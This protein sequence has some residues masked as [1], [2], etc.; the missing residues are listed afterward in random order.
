V[1]SFI[2]VSDDFWVY[3]KLKKNVVCLSRKVALTLI[4]LGLFTAIRDLLT[5]GTKSTRMS[6]ITVGDLSRTETMAA[7]RASRHCTAEQADSS[8]HAASS[9]QLISRSRLLVTRR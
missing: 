2:F 5:V 8:L 4:C 7:I 6:V 3:D 1:L 9:L